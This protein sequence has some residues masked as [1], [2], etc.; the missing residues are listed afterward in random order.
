[1]LF[2]YLNLYL[3]QRGL[4]PGQIGL[5]AAL[6]TWGSAPVS[7][8]ATAAA[9]RLRL[10]K[11]L[12]VAACMASVA[13]RSSL[14]LV[15]DT[16]ALFGVLLAADLLGAPVGPLSDAAVI[17]NCNEVRVGNGRSASAWCRNASTSSAALLPSMH[18]LR[19]RAT[20]NSGSGAA[21][22]GGS[23]ASRRAG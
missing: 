18:R 7:L 2:P 6:R 21:L 3:A 1:M 17:S 13:L 11:Q 20:A 19:V 4:S 8:A 5:L 15:Q 10:H 23:A 16:W 22:A 12:L 14:P 9:D